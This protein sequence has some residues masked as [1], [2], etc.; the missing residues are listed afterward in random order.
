[1]YKFYHAYNE[2]YQKKKE[3]I[4]KHQEEMDRE[5]AER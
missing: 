1:M 5:N 3:P 4:I 2:H